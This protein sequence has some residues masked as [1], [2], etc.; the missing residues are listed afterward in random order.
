MKIA[1]FKELPL[2]GIIR[3]IELDVVEPLIESIVESGL[4]TIEFAMNTKGVKEIIKR[5]KKAAAGRLNIGAGTVTNNALLFEARDAGA[6]FIVMPCFV[7]EVVE[8]CIRDDIPVF[9]G[10]LTPGEVFTAWDAGATMVKV[11]PSA[12]FGPKYF[13]YLKGP[14]NNIQLLAVGGV[15]KENIPEYFSAGASAVACGAS[16]FRRELLAT[17][18]FLTIKNELSDIVNAVM[19]CHTAA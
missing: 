18:D 7:K 14:F 13:S 15:R 9:P 5:A 4:Q 3:G 12:V 1:E 6:E 19:N 8:H 10:A 2:L 17:K 11:F 16:I